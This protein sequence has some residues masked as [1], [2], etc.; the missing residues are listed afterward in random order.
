MKQKLF[1]LPVASTSFLSDPECIH[2][3]RDFEM[4]FDYKSG[5]EQMR[6]VVAFRKVRGYRQRAEIY[7]TEWHIKEAYDTVVEIQDS[8]W[9][10]EFLEI[11]PD[12]HKNSWVMR[13]FMLYVDSFGCLEVLCES[14]ELIE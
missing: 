7:C 6:G 9:S 13:H 10:K 3:G 11:A 12:H 2:A 4:R 14:V 1:S 8:D 5:R